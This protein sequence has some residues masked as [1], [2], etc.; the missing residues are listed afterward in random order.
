[1]KAIIHVAVLVLLSTTI[2]TATTHLPLKGTVVSITPHVL[3][4]KGGSGK[5]DRKFAITK[6]TKILR[7]EANALPTEVKINQIVTGSFIR[8]ENKPDTLTKLQIAPKPSAPK[9][10]AAAKTDADMPKN[11]SDGSPKRG[12]TSARR[13]TGD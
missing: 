11:E 7:G 4:L 6:E 13:A 12:S 10:K 2:L 9:K 5:P 1:M 3:V 8:R